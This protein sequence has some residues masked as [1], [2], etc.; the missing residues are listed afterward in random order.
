MDSI[1]QYLQSQGYSPRKI[2]SNAWSLEECPFCGH[3]GCFRTKDTFFK[4][5]SC[6]AAG[7][8][9]KFE[10]LRSNVSYSEAK[11][12]LNGV[13]HLPNRFNDLIR[14]NHDFLMGHP[15]HLRWLTEERQISVDVLRK[16]RVGCFQDNDGKIHY[17]FPYFTGYNVTNCK[18]RTSDKRLIYFKKGSSQF[19]YNANALRESEAVLVVEGELDCLAAYTYQLDLPCVSVGLGAG[20]YRLSWKEDFSHTK[21][22]YLCFDS[23]EVGQSG[24]RK[25]GEIL[26]SEKCRVVKISKKD[27]N[28]CLKDGIPKE[29][30]EEAINQAKSIAHI[31]IVDA[32]DAIPSN[33]N[34]IGQDIEAA[35]DIIS[36]RPQSEIEDYM[37]LIRERFPAVTYRQGLDFRN[38]IKLLQQKKNKVQIPNTE[39]VSVDIPEHIKNEA[40]AFLKRPDI[41]DCLKNWLT[42]IGIV[43]ESENK[44]ALWL[45]LLSRVTKKPI[46]CVVFGQ[47]SSG[48]SELVKNILLT[49]P[50]QDVLE[51][52]S[53]SSH[54]L[55]YRDGD[56]IGKVI[57]IA[58]LDGAEDVEYIIRV[59]QSEGKIIRAYTIKDESTG[60]LRNVEKTINI[61]SAFVITTT[62]SSIHNEN[63]TR[64]FNLYA[65][66][67]VK[68]TRRV[69]EHIKHSQSRAYKL[70]EPQR[71]HITEV[72]K[73]A[74]MLLEPIEVDVPYA[75]LLDFPDGT[76]RNR[77]DMT[78][79][80][81]FIKIIAILRQHQKELKEDDLGKFIETDIEDYR[82]AHEYLLPIIRNTL[83]EITPRAMAVLEVCCL[84]Q[85]ELN[86]TTNGDDEQF[87]T[88]KDVQARAMEK[89]VD[90]KNVSNLRQEL[91]TLCDGEYME[92]V[93]G[94]WGQK[95]GRHKFRV[96]C[97][98]ELD[99][100]GS[101]RNIHNPNTQILTPDELDSLI[102]QS[103]K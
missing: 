40:M 86:L 33:T 76:T 98:Y 11:S 32:I 73:A 42:E 66:E 67:S 88:T 75:S 85:A 18:Y 48:K 35:L 74:Q 2:G 47:S 15:E 44:I 10:S 37:R 57:A 12:K 84:V 43:G 8:R 97:E 54:A 24:A 17:T 25:L 39:E 55:E 49:I 96:I 29:V 71:K 30:I 70:K 77:R 80:L 5:F 58:E 14:K 92:L 93:S 101:I 23:D 19:L 46:H 9:F 100:D 4:C 60:D 6:E 3:K 83:D 81:S 38:R 31:K 79:F 64:T 7:D 26:G 78:R 36:E 89:G 72:L 62:K 91:Q 45:F 28:D 87:F 13:V 21:T 82:L 65:D 102:N 1:V 51:F 22:I 68:Q 50:D 61:Q 41:L 16:F 53:L 69:I 99:S 27:L 94:Y 20:S 63:A 56:I 90:C 34:V 59:A 52:T 95:G 103:K